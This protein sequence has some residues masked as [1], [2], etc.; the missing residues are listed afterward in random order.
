MN[1]SLDLNTRCIP[2]T[3]AWTN[4]IEQL[5]VIIIHF[6]LTRQSL[7]KLF[8]SFYFYFIHKSIYYY[9]MNFLLNNNF[10]L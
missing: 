3:P 7:S 10:K 6:N 2:Q 8:F 9:N 4:D 1:Y 5:M